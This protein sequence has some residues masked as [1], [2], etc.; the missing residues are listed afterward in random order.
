MV[1]T[2]PGT[3]FQLVLLLLLI[4]S[5]SSYPFVRT[6]LRGPQRDDFSALNRTL[7]ALV[8]STLLVALYALTVGRDLLGRIRQAR[9]PDVEQ[10]LEAVRPLALYALLLLFL[11]PAASAAAVC[12]LGRL[13]PPRFV[14]RLS[15]DPTPSAWDFAFDGLGPLRAGLDVRGRLRRRLVRAQLLCDRLPGATRDFPGDGPPGERRRHVRR[16]VA[17]S[18]GVFINC[19][20]VHLV[21]VVVPPP[22]DQQPAGAT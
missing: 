6:R 8:V 17:N 5:S 10:A 1:P 12:W 9:S 4:L 3:A 19:A 21:E 18:G 16:E 22:V 11:V 14:P 2:I 15:Y 20:D 7:R 13:P